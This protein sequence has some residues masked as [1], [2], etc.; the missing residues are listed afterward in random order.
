M[1]RPSHEGK[2]TMADFDPTRSALLIMDFQNYGLDPKGY[3][4]QRMPEISGRFT[5]AV[6][7]TAR[8]LAA[9]RRKGVTVVFVGQ[10]WR[11]EHP[12][13]AVDSP[14]EAEAKA[15][16]RTVQGTW[17]VE[18]FPP[19]VPAAGELVVYKKTISAF[20]G[21]D[22][23]RFLTIHAIHTLV[24]S[25]LAT[26][27]VVEGTAREASDRG[28]QVIVLKDCCAAMTD[29]E[30]EFPFRT[31]FQWISTI[32]SSDEFIQSLG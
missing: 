22:L 21:T 10:A 12:D 18:F 16:G 5:R 17:D 24:L 13:A 11:E 7:N 28:Y 30:H 25:G 19:L 27:G 9:A 3:W 20:T 26:N 14:W 8:A 15:A 32:S 6:A 29:E 31:I 1:P 2:V 4:P 23:D